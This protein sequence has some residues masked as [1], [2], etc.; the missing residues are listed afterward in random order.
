MNES[1]DP[2]ARHRAGT[3]EKEPRS[4]PRSETSTGSSERAQKLLDFL[5]Y[6]TKPTIRARDI[7]IY[8][9]NPIR[10]RERAIDSAEI[11]VKSGWLV[12]IKTRQRNMYAWQVVR[13][14]ILHPTVAGAAGVAGV[15]TE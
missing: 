14:P 9:P 2:F 4:Q 7:C 10:R 8:G 13:R 3:S 1:V 11:L 12:R 6:W 15:A 5:Q